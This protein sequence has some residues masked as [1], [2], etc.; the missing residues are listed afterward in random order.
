MALKDD[1]EAQVSDIFKAQWTERN[2]Q[3]VPGDT[4]LKLGNDAV[5]LKATVLYG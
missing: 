5:K 1:L 4:S 3:V 2:G